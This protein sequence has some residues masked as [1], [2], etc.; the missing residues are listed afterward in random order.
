[1]M[2]WQPIETAPKDGTRVLVCD[3]DAEP[4]EVYA[5]IYESYYPNVPIREGD[6]KIGWVFF[7]FERGPEVC[8]PAYW[9]PLAAAPASN[10][11][12]G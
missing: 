9:M 10:Q 2:D 5:C 12:G 8:T 11:N 1:M 6:T 7:A 3:E 4:G